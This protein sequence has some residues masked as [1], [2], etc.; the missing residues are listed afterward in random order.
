[1]WSLAPSMPAQVACGDLH[2]KAYRLA[3]VWQ[4][5]DSGFREIMMGARIA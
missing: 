5:C 1:M 3:L 2:W 4:G